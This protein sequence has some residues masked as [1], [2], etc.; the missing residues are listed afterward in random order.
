MFSLLIR[1]SKLYSIPKTLLVPSLQ[2]NVRL[3][4]PMWHRLP[5][6]TIGTMILQAVGRVS[7]VNRDES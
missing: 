6:R 2:S 4:I 3:T 1:H 7:N 5:V